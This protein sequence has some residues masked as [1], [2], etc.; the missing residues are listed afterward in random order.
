MVIGLK[1]SLASRHWSL[2]IQYSILV[3]H[4]LFLI[5]YYFPCCGIS[6]ALRYFLFSNFSDF[7]CGA[8]KS[9]LST[10]VSVWREK[11]SRLNGKEHYCRAKI[12]V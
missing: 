10:G 6:A 3:I 1:A 2:D 7:L 4:F 5:P 11:I 9:G 8:E 12:C